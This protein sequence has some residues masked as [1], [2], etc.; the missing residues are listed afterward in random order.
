MRSDQPTLVIFVHGFRS[1]PECWDRLV[2]LLDDNPRFRDSFH[3]QKFEY[4][5]RWFRLSF[6]RR[7]PSLKEIADQLKTFLELEENRAYERVILVGHSQGGLVIQSYL[8]EELNNER[9]A[10]L[11]RIVQAIFI[12]TP[13]LGSTLFSGLRRLLFWLNPQ[14]HSLRVLNEEISVVNR[15]VL[16]RIENATVSDKTH[17]QI[18]IKCFWGD[19][20]AVVLPAS[21]KG[22]FENVTALSGDHFSVLRPAGATDQSFLRI[23][24]AL[25]SPSGHKS[26]HEVD[27]YE[28]EIQVRPVAP[29]S[30]YDFPTLHRVRH[31]ATDNIASIRRSIRFR[32]SNRC[33]NFFVLRYAT[34]NDGFIKM[35]TSHANL[36]DP[37][38]LGR[39][40]DNGIEASFRFE[41]QQEETFVLELEVYKG[42]D[43]NHRDFHMHVPKHAHYR[44]ISLVLDLRPYLTAGWRVTRQPELFL[45]AEDVGHSDL[46][47][48]RAQPAKRES[49]TANAPGRWFWKIEDVTQGV[50]DLRW[51]IAREQAKDASV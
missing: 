30:T 40:E 2:G 50:L 33:K 8:A 1:G 41:P 46:C 51:D 45:Y 23:L 20:D 7:I 4:Q 13:H 29:D 5:T 21:A 43:D 26:V 16:E 32:A 38:E 6:L 19:Q 15:T 49:G 31:V 24:E 9:G 42:F 44:E 18:P 35:K 12:C 17:R 11:G 28:T 10:A 3:R 27:L 47:R 36:A 14:E 39:Y 37:A 25:L 22:Q 48:N 34:R